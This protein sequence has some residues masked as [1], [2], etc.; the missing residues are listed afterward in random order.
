[1]PKEKVSM[2]KK[3][4][5]QLKNT[6][7]KRYVTKTGKG[8]RVGTL[9]RDV[10]FLKSIINS[11]KRRLFQ[12]WTSLLVGQTNFNGTTLNP[13]YNML[14][15][16]PIPSQGNNVSG[17]AGSSI[18]LTAS[19]MK[20]Q[21]AQQTNCQSNIRYKIIIVRVN[22]DPQTVS[23]GASSGV[24]KML[25]APTWFSAG[26][27]GANMSLFHDY[28]STRNPDYFKTFQVLAVR[29]GTVT[30]DSVSGAL[31]TSEV[32][33]KMRYN[34]G[35]GIHVRYNADSNTV[36]TGQLFAL[37][38]TD[39]GNAGG[40]TITNAPGGIIDV[41]ALTGLNVNVSNIHYYYD[42]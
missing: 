3:V 2:L 22:G 39:R 13:G 19:Y 30:P 29:T 17:R 23:V 20:F 31:N 32:T 24:N 33:I 12:T 15:I 8:L 10:M 28:N 21:L 41:N 37:L 16:T 1:M 7:K 26:S 38:F 36:A 27:S 11:E 4:G 18:K 35:Q 6:L 25:S 14:D 42:N 34:K 9:A 40:T 5:R